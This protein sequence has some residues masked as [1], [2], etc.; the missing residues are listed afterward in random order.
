MVAMLRWGWRPAEFLQLPEAEKALVIAGLQWQVDIASCKSGQTTLSAKSCNSKRPGLPASPPGSAKSR[1][2]SAAHSG[3]SSQ[4]C[5]WAAG[6]AKRGGAV[7]G[8]GGG[9]S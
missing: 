7:W 5:G 3:A 9:E 2:T 4:S 8:G 6:E 1:C